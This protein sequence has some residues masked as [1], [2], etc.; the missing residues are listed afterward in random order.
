LKHTGK[1]VSVNAARPEAAILG[2]AARIIRNGGVVVFPTHGLYGLGA[3]PLNT[4]A[5]ERIFAIKGRQAHKALLVLIADLAS[6]ERVAERPNAQAQE[7][8][9]HFWPG[10][11]TI[12]LRARPELPAAV[13]GSDGTIGVRLVAHPVAAALVRAVGGP[14]TGTSANISG[15]GGCATLE[16][17]DAGLLDGVDLTLDA[18]PLAGGPG[19]TVVDATGRTLRI[20]RE[21]AVPSEEIR[22]VWSA[23]VIACNFGS[24]LTHRN[25]KY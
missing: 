11:V 6:L 24:E 16:A 3:D 2:R 1:I 20:L 8:M 21:G 13:T 10:R 25:I 5:V 9:R 18:G 15:S 22:R 7:L 12:V 14:I 23:R 17:M 19:S 4:A